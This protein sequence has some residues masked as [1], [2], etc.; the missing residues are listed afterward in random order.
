MQWNRSFQI[1]HHHHSL[2]MGKDLVY[3]IWSKEHPLGRYASLN[4][5]IQAYKTQ[6]WLF[7]TFSLASENLVNIVNNIIINRHG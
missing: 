2:I 7:L 1:F 5:L 6:K 4:H 3:A